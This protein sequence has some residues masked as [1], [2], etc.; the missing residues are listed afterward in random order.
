MKEK[1]MSLSSRLRINMLITIVPMVGLLLFS[2]VSLVSTANS[3]DQIVRNITAANAYSIDFKQKVDYAMYRVVI[4]NTSV[5]HLVATNKTEVCNPYEL[6]EETRQVFENLKGISQKDNLRRIKNILKNLDNLKT[7]I[8]RIETNNLSTAH[9]YDENMRLLELN[10]YILTEITQEQIQEYIYYEASALEDVRQML[11][12]R[13]EL[14]IILTLI[15]FVCY[16]F[17]L[18]LSNKKVN[19]SITRPVKE[20]CVATESLAKGDFSTTIK[21]ASYDY[22]IATLAESFNHMK[23]E[24]SRLIDTIKEEQ[25]NLRATELQLYQAQINPHF[26]YNTLDT[27]VALVECR[28]PHEAVQMITALS[29]FFRT[30]L[31]EGRD[32]ILISEEE[33]HVRSYLKIQQMRYQD[34][35][36]YSIEIDPEMYQYTILKLTLQP[37]VENALYHGIKEK[38]GKGFIRILGMIENATLVFTI[39]DNGIG[40]NKEHLLEITQRMNRGPKK[41]NE[42][43]FGLYNVQQR[44]LLN[45]GPEYGVTF[46][47]R[48]GEGTTATVVIPMRLDDSEKIPH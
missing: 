11:H 8:Q 43:G 32:F 40:M 26:L 42:G 1:R 48:E 47:S 36:D 24:I 25:K 19:D 9:H 7:Q 28:M 14:T 30:T 21:D 2:L 6:I 37:L 5:Q 3:Y 4:A 17:S 16:L 31:S 46:S 45:Y 13:V 15:I 20:L 10:I 34:I 35:L 27:I 18:W 38:R 33:S 41:K 44:I 39:N 29:D 22:E 12:G 23:R